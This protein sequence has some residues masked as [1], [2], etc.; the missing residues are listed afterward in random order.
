[1]RLAAFD[2]GKHIEKVLALD[3][4]DR[5]L[6]NLGQDILGEYPLGQGQRGLST[7]LQ[8]QA[9]VGV[10]LFEEGFEGIFSGQLGCS[11]LLLAV[12]ARIRVGRDKGADFIAE[13]A[14]REGRPRG[15]SPATCA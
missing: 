7:L 3:V 12:G 11:S 9:A 2:R 5:V 4:V 13:G 1:M 8:E 15:R 10:P 6:T 14:P